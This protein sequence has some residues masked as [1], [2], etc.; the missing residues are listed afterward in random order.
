MILATAAGMSIFGETDTLRYTS[1][2]VSR[3]ST[4]VY[5]G[6]DSALRNIVSFISRSKNTL[7]QKSSTEHSNSWVIV[8]RLIGISG[9]WV[10]QW[11]RDLVEPCD[12]RQ[13]Q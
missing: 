10:Y 3:N 8:K 1:A 5:S 13:S 4:T 2:S 6:N 7:D 12:G 9:A 11:P